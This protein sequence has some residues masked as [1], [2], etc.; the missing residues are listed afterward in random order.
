[1]T[2]LPASVFGMARRGRVAVGAV[3]DLV[4]FDLETLR[5][6]ATY[7]KP[8]Q[9]AEGMVHVLVAGKLAIEARKFTP[10]RAGRVLSRRDR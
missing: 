9:L 6:R 3:A 5:D 7:R 2:S 4:V 1:M 10:A 8:H